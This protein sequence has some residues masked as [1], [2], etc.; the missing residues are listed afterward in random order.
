VKKPPP[1]PT[2]SGATCGDCRYW[3]KC[4]TDGEVIGECYWNPPVVQMDEDG[5]SLVRP[6]LDATEHACGRFTGGQ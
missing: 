6:I 3:R 5:Y 2:D 1:A 4:D